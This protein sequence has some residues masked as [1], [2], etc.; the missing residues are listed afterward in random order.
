VLQRAESAPNK[1]V[2]FIAAGV[3]VY[4]AFKA[5]ALIEKEIGQK[6]YGD[7]RVFS[8]TPR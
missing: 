8:Q 2:T 6:I 3:M 4:E 1:G 5:A 7:R